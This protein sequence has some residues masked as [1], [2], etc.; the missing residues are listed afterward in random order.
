[1]GAMFLF[2]VHLTDSL[3]RW[4]DAHEH[5]RARHLPAAITHAQRWLILSQDKPIAGYSYDGWEVWYA[6]PPSWTD[7]L[8]AKGTLQEAQLANPAIG[9]AVTPTPKR[10]GRAVA[11][12]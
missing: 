7:K 5:S 8:R 2:I 1:M 10:P 4:P 9:G 6:Q 12:T 3:G 11:S